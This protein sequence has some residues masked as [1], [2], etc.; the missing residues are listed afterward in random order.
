MLIGVCLFILII[1]MIV[2][3]PALAPFDPFKQNFDKKFLPPN[4]TH[5]F[6]TD[7]FGRDILSRVLLGARYTI[8]SGIGVVLLAASIGTVLGLISGFSGGLISEIIMRLADIFIA[9]P[10]LILAILVAATLGP[11]LT[12]SLI[13]LSITWW[14]WY[15]RLIRGQVLSIR[16]SLYI[17]AARALGLSNSRIIFRHILPN[18]AS[19]LIVQITMDFSYS[20]LYAAFLGFVGL[21]AQVPTPEWGLMISEGFS[22]IM[23]G[24]W[25]IITFPGLFIMLAV[26]CFALLGDGL[27][28]I[29]NP[30]VKE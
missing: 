8:L 9:F 11:G 17:E 30:R 27:N 21:G 2:L 22:Y 16:E 3:G 12:N 29:L 10:S 19:P 1:I 6:G 7:Q 13:A 20:I 14:P 24:A 4:L 23:L 5:P 15:C 25:W 26:I 18:C 28:D